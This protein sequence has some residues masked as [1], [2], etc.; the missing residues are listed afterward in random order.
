MKGEIDGLLSELELTRQHARQWSLADNMEGLKRAAVSA[1]R[2][3]VESSLL[4]KTAVS[5]AEAAEAAK[6]ASTRAAED[7]I[8]SSQATIQS[9]QERIDCLLSKE[10][11]VT[12][13]V[14]VFVFSDTCVG[15]GVGEAVARISM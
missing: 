13:F 11:E 2:A 6:V 10:F 1:E 8:R 3:A 9:L 7:R 5:R 12:L 15:T 14:S 4:A